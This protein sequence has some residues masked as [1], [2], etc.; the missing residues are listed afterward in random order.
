[1]LTAAPTFDVA[2]VCSLRLLRAA[3]RALCLLEHSCSFEFEIGS[4]QL[5]ESLNCATEVLVYRGSMHFPLTWLI[6]RAAVNVYFTPTQ[7]TIA[8]ARMFDRNSQ[9]IKLE[10]AGLN[11][12][13]RWNDNRS[14]PRSGAFQQPL[15]GTFPRVANDS[16]CRR[17]CKVT[18]PIASITCNSVSKLIR[19]SVF[20]RSF[21]SFPMRKHRL[22]LNIFALTWN[23]ERFSW[24]SYFFQ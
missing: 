11:D 19:Y 4:S 9:A 14:S 13:T 16:K 2:A 22:E 12:I 15:L 7:A 8:Q 18:S 1:M 5:V 10:P 3:A 17:E 20:S 23:A 21:A 6:V 24:R